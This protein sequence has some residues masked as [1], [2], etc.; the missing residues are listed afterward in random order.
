LECKFITRLSQFLGNGCIGFFVKNFDLNALVLGNGC[1]RISIKNLDLDGV[2]VDV[3]VWGLD[4]L[5]FNQ[6]KYRL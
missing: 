1:T 2:D 3:D 5:L 6:G 4:D